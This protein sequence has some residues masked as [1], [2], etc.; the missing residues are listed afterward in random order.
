MNTETPHHGGHEWIHS[1]TIDPHRHIYDEEWVCESGDLQMRIYHSIPC[2]DD[3]FWLAEIS[4]GHEPEKG[5]YRVCGVMVEDF[6]TARTWCEATLPIAKV[7]LRDT[8]EAKYCTLAEA[9]TRIA[10]LEAENAKE[11]QYC[12]DQI[13]SYEI[14]LTRE[15]ARAEKVQAKLDVASEC[16]RGE[17]QELCA[18]CEA[19]CDAGDMIGGDDDSG[20]YCCDCYERWRF[21]CP[22]KRCTYRMEELEDG[23]DTRCPECG[24]VMVERCVKEGLS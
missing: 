2:D 9:L 1:E 24:E 16:L 18:G 5:G 6:D 4:N 13:E 7:I 17:G 3:E 20:P 19:W 12:S 14:A 22:R 21:E 10:E 8:V 15:K 23:A 11:H